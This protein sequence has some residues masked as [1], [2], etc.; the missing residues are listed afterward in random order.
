[1]RPMRWIDLSQREG[2]EADAPLFAFQRAILIALVLE[3]ACN[4]DRF[5][6]DYNDIDLV[7]F[8]KKLD[9]ILSRLL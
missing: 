6:E 3:L 7:D 9:D 8:R 2:G 5:L 1:M 4:P